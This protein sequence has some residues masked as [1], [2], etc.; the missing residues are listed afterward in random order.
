[1][2][3]HR[4]VSSSSIR[5]IPTDP[6]CSN[7][8]FVDRE[9]AGVSA[10][11][12]TAQEY[13]RHWRTAKDWQANIESRDLCS[14]VRPLLPGQLWVVEVS[15]PELFPSNVRKVGEIILDATQKPTAQRD[16]RLFVCA[17][18]PGSLLVLQDVSA[19]GVPLFFSVPSRLQ[20]HTPLFGC[21]ARRLGRKRSMP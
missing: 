19:A 1:V 8:D 2:S 15:V 10:I 21:E 14:A 12:L 4:L 5:L 16:F 6:P 3:T 20:S 9:F 11:C 13:I 17:R 7:F 18:V